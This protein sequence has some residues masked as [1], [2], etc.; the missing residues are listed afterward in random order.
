M[1]A[2][3]TRRA[4]GHQGRHQRRT[5][6]AASGSGGAAHR[7]AEPTVNDESINQEVPT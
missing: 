6:V 3:V 7:V 5:L 4:V 1:R 2:L